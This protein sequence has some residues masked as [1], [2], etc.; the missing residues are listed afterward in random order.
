[1]ENKYMNIYILGY[2]KWNSKGLSTFSSIEDVDDC[3]EWCIV[4]A[5]NLR[6]AKKAYNKTFK[7]WQRENELIHKNNMKMLN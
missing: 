5:K 6:M 4:K 2:K 1:M 7:K 3:E